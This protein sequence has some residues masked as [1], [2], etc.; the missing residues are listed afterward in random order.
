[1]QIDVGGKNYKLQHPGNR[2]WL[3]LQKKM[4]NSSTNQIDLEAMLDYFFEH[5]CFPETGANLSID[6]LSLDELQEVWA[7]VA[8]QF[9]AGKC[10]PGTRYF[11][12]KD[13]WEMDTKGTAGTQSQQSP[14]LPGA[15]K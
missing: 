3:R 7:I 5:C 13:K 6:T 12:K 11:R 4:F 8:P 1:M 2:E 15:G 9:L 14:Q 10:E